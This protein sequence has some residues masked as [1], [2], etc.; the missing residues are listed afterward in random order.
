[1][2]LSTT[3]LDGPTNSPPVADLSAPASAVQGQQIT[4]DAS[5]SSDPDGDA[6]TYAW[7]LD[8]DGA[9]DDATGAT[10]QHSFATPGMQ[11]VG[12]EVSDGTDT[13]STA[14]TVE[15]AYAAPLDV[16]PGS[17][18]N[19]VN[20]KAKGVL[21]VA[22]LNTDDFDP[23]AVVVESLVLSAT[24]GGDGASPVRGA[25]YEDV[26]GDGY[27]DLVVKFATAD[28]GIESTSS[29]LYL[30]GEMADGMSLVGSDDVTVVGNDKSNNGNSRGR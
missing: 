4:L 28:I 15:V 14:A 21:T 11:T 22:I 9:F 7:D 19:P 17:D 10:V 5:G 20:A 8:G 30:S 23:S 1:M 3:P 6:L 13:N 16:K 29:T 24:T 25:H 12:V 26:D 18:D 2:T 27:D